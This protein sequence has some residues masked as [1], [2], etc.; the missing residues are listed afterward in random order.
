MAILTCFPD[1]DEFA[2]T[3][4]CMTQL[5]ADIKNCCPIAYDILDYIQIIYCECLHCE[6]LESVISCS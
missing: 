1:P 2:L 4:V 6:L 5:L 3:V